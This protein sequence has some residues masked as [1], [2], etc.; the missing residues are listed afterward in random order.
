[1]GAAEELDQDGE[2]TRLLEDLQDVGLGWRWRGG[3][4]GAGDTGARDTGG[5][6]KT[7]GAAGEAAG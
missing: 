7:S 6:G 4:S 1:M 2:A 5:G 3:E